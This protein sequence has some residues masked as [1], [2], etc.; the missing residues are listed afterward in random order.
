MQN[1]DQQNEKFYA[2]FIAKPRLSKKERKQAVIDEIWEDD[3]EEDEDDYV[4]LS[5]EEEKLLEKASPEKQKK[6]SASHPVRQ[7]DCRCPVSKKCSGCQMQNLSY[8]D[9]LHWKQAQEVRLLGSYGRVSPILGMD[10]PLHYRNKVQ[11]AFG[12]THGGKIISGVWQSK[13]QKITAVDHCMIEDQA[14]SD[15]AV[16]VRKLL[17]AFK[18]TAWQ[19]GSGF[20]RHLLIRR[21][22]STGEIMVVLVA[23]TPVFPS[24][25]NF[26]AALLRAHPEITT[27]VF[28][29]N[30]SDTNLLLG[31]REEVLYGKGYIEDV[32]CG[33]TFRISPKSFYQVNPV[34]T[35]RLYQTAIDFARLSGK[36]TVLD[37]YCGI[38]TIGLAAAKNAGEVI[39]VEVNPNAVKDAVMN[40]KCNGIQNARFI[41]ADAGEY[42]TE[43]AGEGFK[44]DVLFMDPPRAGADSAFI[45]AVLLSAPEKIVYISC[46]PETQARDLR[47][48]TAKKAY[49]VSRIQPVDMFPWTHH[50]ESVVLLEKLRPA[51]RNDHA[52]KKDVKS[53]KNTAVKHTRPSRRSQFSN[54]NNRAFGKSGKSART[55]A[56]SVPSRSFSGKKE[57]RHD[58]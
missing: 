29:V 14:A 28:T 13:E 19:N 17:S 18:M 55:S 34:Q 30:D 4:I 21:G 31:E 42:M 40:A 5:E 11:T 45:K 39:G 26:T 58:K 37:A 27:V 36:E 51:G 8:K 53:G 57:L 33:L 23:G 16:T 2:K 46:N 3:D 54:K 35:E 52:E 38:G 1:K 9:G 32:L 43:L 22:F 10:Q 47:L 25:K 12:M 48:L 50:I 15:I 44:P 7:N 49:K 24:K 6:D 56:E 41:Q 20:L